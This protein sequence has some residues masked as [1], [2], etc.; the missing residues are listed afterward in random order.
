MRCV[1]FVQGR[2]M[3][4]T[5][6][7][8]EDNPQNMRLVR[9]ILVHHG[10]EVLEATDGTTGVALALTHK[11][12]IVLMDINLP[13]IDGREAARS[14]KVVHPWLPVI[15]LTANAMYGD[16]ERILSAGCDGYISKPISKENLLN[17]V[18]RFLSSINLNNTP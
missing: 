1:L 12:D 13:D 18:A 9:K 10:Y 8:I 17:V 11:P 14:I 15:A 2:G 5:I 3:A 16:E 6:L 7:Y 4:Q